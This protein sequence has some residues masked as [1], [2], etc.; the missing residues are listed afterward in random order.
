MA[1][2]LRQV[3]RYCCSRLW[4]KQSLTF[5]FFLILSA[6]FWLFQTLSETADRE[7][8]VPL[9]LRGVPQN[10]VITTDPPAALHVTLRDKAGML[11]SYALRG[12]FQPVEIDFPSAANATGHVT[13]QPAELLR[14]LARQLEA[15]TQI[16]ASKPEAIEFY[17]NYGLCKRVPVEVDADVKTGSMFSLSATRVRHDSVTVYASRALLDNITSVRTSRIELD[18][19][20]DTTRV[21]A[22]LQAVKGAK[23]VPNAT[24][25]TFC[26][27]RVVEKTV[28]VPVQQVNFPATKQLRT[29][30]ASVSVSFQVPMG[31]Y[32]DV[33]KESFVL[34][35]NYEDLLRS[36]SAKCHLS[37]KSVPRGV[38]HVRIVPQDVEYI[39][40]EL[41]ETEGGE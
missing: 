6:T 41:P 31:M 20:T 34:V 26:V 1:T 5:L 40:E 39:I 2:K 22:D 16:V 36:K 7:F 27:D 17:Y 4:S 23:F 33:T 18:G 11:L 9:K 25:V 30:P 37:L 12:G 24:T 8:D 35:V 10:V 32:R 19:V 3:V 13:L 21:K 38:S 28:Q 29:F 15:G 14:Q